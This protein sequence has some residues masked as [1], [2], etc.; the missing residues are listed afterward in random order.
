MFGLTVM[1]GLVT[2]AL[3]LSVALWMHCEVQYGINQENARSL[4]KKGLH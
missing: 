3:D 4:Y 1:G 2:S